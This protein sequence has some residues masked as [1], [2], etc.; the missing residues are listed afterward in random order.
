MECCSFLKLNNKL[1]DTIKRLS[2]IKLFK[3]DIHDL[4]IN[5]EPYMVN[6]YT[7]PTNYQYMYY[8]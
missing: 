6:E 4:L 3:T 1:P 5:L 2:N 8:Y 7:I